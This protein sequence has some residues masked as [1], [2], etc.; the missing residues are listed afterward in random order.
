M[1][2]ALSLMQMSSGSL[3]SLTP[4]ACSSTCPLP[5][6]AS[7]C[8]RHTCTLAHSQ[9]QYLCQISMSNI[10]VGYLQTRMSLHGQCSLFVCNSAARCNREGRAGCGCFGPSLTPYVSVPPPCLR[11][12]LH[13]HKNTGLGEDTQRPE[14]LFRRL[15]L[16]FG[17]KMLGQ[18]CMMCSLEK[19]QEQT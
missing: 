13:K 8:C 4:P 6:W 12:C 3:A 10:Y 5:A 16:S 2:T 7:W 14:Q 11:T 19:H 15:D 18:V 17:L 1:V 9:V